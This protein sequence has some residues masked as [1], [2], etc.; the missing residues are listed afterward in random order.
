M[1]LSPVSFPRGNEEV[2]TRGEETK[3][4]LRASVGRSVRGR[5]L[6]R[7][8]SQ[9][10]ASMQDADVENLD[11]TPKNGPCGGASV[12]GR[13]LQGFEVGTLYANTTRAFFLFSP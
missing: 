2:V 4:R 1:S 5:R 3:N 10:H 8:L 11:T 9:T 6:P 13:D 7:I 12:T